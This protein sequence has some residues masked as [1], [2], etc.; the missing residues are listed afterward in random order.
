MRAVVGVST[1]GAVPPV[2]S[3]VVLIGFGCLS[4]ITTVLFGFGGGFVTVPVIYAL[5]SAT[6]PAPGTSP[7]GADAMHVAVATSAAV[8][9]V[10]SLCAT[11]AQRRSGRLRREYLWPLAGS[12]ALGA[13]VGSLAATRVPDGL[14]R[15][16]FL[17][18][19]T[20]TIIDSLA[21][22][23]FLTPHR[24]T[25]SGEHPPGL[26]AGVATAGGAGIGAVAS[27]LGVGGSVMTV[28]L[29]RR[30]GLPMADATALANPLS[31]PVAAIAT[32]IYTLAAPRP[33]AAGHLGYIDVLAAAALLC[34]SLPTIAVVRKIVGRI[35]D[36]EHAIAYIGLLILS[37]LAVSIH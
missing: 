15:T 13:V 34:G 5:T 22:R 7:A 9:L 12:I 17:L 27:F 23:G 26:A 30:S 19:L 25:H 14:L 3:V 32:M 11:F 20:A 16:L 35:P 31:L 10:N 33:W 8:M 1:V 29:M 21:R 6:T 18:Y 37:L 2:L 28:P 36:R 4:G 24:D